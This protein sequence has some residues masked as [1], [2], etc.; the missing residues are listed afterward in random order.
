[1]KP[2]RQQIVDRIR[3]LGG[4]KAEQ[5][6]DYS[7]YDL[8]EDYENLLRIEIEKEYTEVDTDE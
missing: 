1:M 2:L 7:D 6:E 8:L 4:A 5:Y 3:G